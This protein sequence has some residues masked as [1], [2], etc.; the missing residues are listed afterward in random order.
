MHYVVLYRLLTVPNEPTAEQES[1]NLRAGGET[2]VFLDFAQPRGKSTCKS[3]TNLC[4]LF[5]C[6]VSALRA[7]T[8][9]YG[10]MNDY[11]ISLVYLYTLFSSLLSRRETLLEEESFGTLEDSESCGRMQRPRRHPHSIRLDI[12][13]DL[14]EAA[15]ADLLSIRAECACA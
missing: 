9:L 1:P 6:V 5:V 13:L 12:H 7:A 8:T 4:V 14:H 15:H 2:L 3:V 10:Y 11:L